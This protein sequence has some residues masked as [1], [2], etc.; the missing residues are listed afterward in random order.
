M[1][2]QSFVSWYRVTLSFSG[3]VYAKRISGL[4]M[5]DGQ[6]FVSESFWYARCLCFQTKVGAYL[7]ILKWNGNLSHEK[8]GANLSLILKVKAFRTFKWSTQGDPMS[9]D[10]RLNVNICKYD[11]EINFLKW[12]RP[13]IKSSIEP[14]R[15]TCCQRH[16]TV[17]V[18]SL[19]N[20]KNNSTKILLPLFHWSN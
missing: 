8:F 13:H 11:W 4:W 17:M 14:Y 20:T 5:Y 12:D 15:L 7:L 2:V 3:F 10:K 18:W 1:D 19:K 9:L 6:L 16:Q